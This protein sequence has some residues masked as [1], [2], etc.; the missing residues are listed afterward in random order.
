MLVAGNDVGIQRLI[1]PFDLGIVGRFPRPDDAVPNAKAGQP[2]RKLA[3]EGIGSMADKDWFAIGLDLF[4][5][6]LPVQ[7][8]CAEGS[9]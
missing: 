4:R 3:G 5:Q 1:S 2:E 6:G 9:L 7:K 8:T